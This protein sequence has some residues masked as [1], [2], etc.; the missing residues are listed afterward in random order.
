MKKI[1][2][3]ML[4]VLLIFTSCSST[5]EVVAVEPVPEVVPVL[6]EPAKPATSTTGAF[7]VEG[8]MITGGLAAV[9]IGDFVYAAGM[10]DLGYQLTSINQAKANVMQ[11]YAEHV[12]VLIQSAMENYAQGGG[13]VNSSKEKDLQSV[14]NNAVGTQIVSR[15]QISGIEYLDMQVTDNEAV[16]ILS[17]VK[18]TS[19]NDY[20]KKESQNI[21]RNNASV[22]ANQEASDFFTK[23]STQGIF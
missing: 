3:V 17:R 14:V 12:S 22:K 13:I 2:F 15:A 23:L 19:L 5:K 21:L 1:L 20:V 10:G 16:Y 8:Q 6:P 4:A 18:K 7:F 11:L 9:E